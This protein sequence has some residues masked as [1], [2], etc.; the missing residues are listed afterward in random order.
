[1]DKEIE[2]SKSRSDI[3]HDERR[4]SIVGKHQHHSPRHSTSGEHNSSMSSPIR[5]HKTRFGVDKLQE[6]MNEIKP[7]TF[8]GEHKKD[9][10]AKT[11]LLGMRKYF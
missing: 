1:M 5:N 7:P 3:Y 4:R 6:E 8:D 2:S 10:D 9:D 11:W